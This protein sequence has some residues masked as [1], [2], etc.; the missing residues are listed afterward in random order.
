MA[1]TQTKTYTVQQVA[2][3]VGMSRQ[4]LMILIKKK[5]FPFPVIQVGTNWVVPRVAV[6][7]F[8]NDDS[9]GF[10]DLVN[11]QGG[12]PVKWVKGEFVTWNYRLPIDLAEAFK[13]VVENMNKSLPVPIG[14]LDARCL[15]IQEFVERRPIE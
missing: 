15:A 12:R 4:D 9:L 13:V 1:V 5:K 10:K 11:G 8:M 6:D 14:L 3:M 7:R 2:E